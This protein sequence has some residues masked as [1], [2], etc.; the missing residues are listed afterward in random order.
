M[1][2][3]KPFF[4]SGPRLGGWGWPWP[5]EEG[6]EDERVTNRF[7]SAVLWKQEQAHLGSSKQVGKKVELCVWL[8]A[9]CLV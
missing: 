7:M 4:S 6:E 9:C 3:G 5:A 1:R 8:L 2:P